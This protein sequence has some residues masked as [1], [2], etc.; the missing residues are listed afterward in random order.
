[1]FSDFK[2]FFQFKIQILFKIRTNGRWKH[3]NFHT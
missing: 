3:K 1:M 2:N